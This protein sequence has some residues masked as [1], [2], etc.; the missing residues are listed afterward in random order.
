MRVFISKN[1]F[2]TFRYSCKFFQKCLVFEVQ[3]RVRKWLSDHDQFL[4]QTAAETATVT[5]LEVRILCVT[6]SLNNNAYSFP[7]NPLPSGNNI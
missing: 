5:S 3:R 1:L 4:T 6:W 2:C 7:F